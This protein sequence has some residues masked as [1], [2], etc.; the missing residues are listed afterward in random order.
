MLSALPRSAPFGVV[1]T[2]TV[3]LLGVGT[4][5]HLGWLAELVLD[6]GLSPL[7]DLPVGLSAEGRPY[8]TLFRLAEAIAGVAFMLS[9]P[10]LLRLAPVH[11]QG[12]L[13]VAA[14]FSFGAL[15]LVR[16]GYPPDCVPALSEVCAPRGDLSLAHRVNVVASALLAVQY[17]V[18]PAVLALWWH[19]GWG[20]VARC[21]VGIESAAGVA[22]ATGVVTGISRFAG[23]AARVQ[24]VAMSVLLC[25]GMA[26]LVAVGRRV[27]GREGTPWSRT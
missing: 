24:L 16:A 22:L 3:L 11:P 21:V 5:A 10:P 13:T 27:H 2:A 12:R 8:R 14:V 15:M 17:V 18:G 6:T 4:A 1:R 9:T 23:V 25:A 19:G 20:L 7:H 26:Y